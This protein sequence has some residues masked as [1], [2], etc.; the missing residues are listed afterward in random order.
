MYSPHTSA[1]TIIATRRTPH[2]TEPELRE[3]GG[4]DGVRAG[5]AQGR[6]DEQQQPEVTGGEPDRIPQ[7]VR[8]VLRDE[9]GDTEKRGGREVL[10]RDRRRVPPRP[11][12]A[13]RHQEVGWCAPDAPRRF[14]MP[15]VAT[16]AATSANTVRR[17]WAVR[18]WAPPSVVDQVGEVLFVALCRADVEPPPPT[19]SAAGRSP[20]AATADGPRRPRRRRRR[21]HEQQDGHHREQQPDRRRDPRGEAQLARTSPRIIASPISVCS[22]TSTR[23]RTTGAAP[24]GEHHPFAGGWNGTRRRH[25]D[26]QFLTRTRMSLSFSSRCAA[27]HRQLHDGAV[28]CGRRHTTSRSRRCGCRSPRRATRGTS[29]VPAGTR[30]RPSDSR[31]TRW[32]C[33]RGAIRCRCAGARSRRRPPPLDRRPRHQCRHTA[34]FDGDHL[35]GRRVV[36]GVVLRSASTLDDPAHR[37]REP[38]L[39]QR[40]EQVVDGTEVERRDG[41]VLVRGHEH[42]RRRVRELSEDPRQLQ[43]V[44][45]GHV[46]VGR[47]RIDAAVPQNAQRGGGVSRE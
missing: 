38:L 32:G 2:G 20:R 15:T 7:R 31:A 36:V 44:E 34:E 27:T 16:A 47:N 3:I 41:P 40:L 1:T 14:P 21:E 19:G 11:D 17:G 10:T 5:A 37:L 18:S 42:H 6:R 29:G 35:V 13:R 30:H 9:A 8:T 39:A 33:V 45:P 23:V 26:V 25:L 4:G 22:C 12:T 46:D 43:T 24:L 28:P